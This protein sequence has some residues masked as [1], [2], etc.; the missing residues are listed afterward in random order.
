MTE[1]ASI[2]TQRIAAVV[3]GTFSGVV[4]MV[5]GEISTCNLSGPVGLAE[6]MGEAAQSGWQTFLTML[7]MVSLG[8]GILNLLPIPVLDGGHLAFFA[9]EAIARRKPNPQVMNLAVM[10]GLFFVVSL[11][12]FA[13]GNDL[14]CV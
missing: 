14:V 12:I 9:Y 10:V 4:H 8:V 11:T 3:E 7:A 13:L 6:T 2:A 1:A 5:R